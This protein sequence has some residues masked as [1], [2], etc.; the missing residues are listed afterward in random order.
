MAITRKMQCLLRAWVLYRQFMAQ[1]LFKWYSFTRKASGGFRISSGTFAR[2]FLWF[3]QSQ[4]T[5]HLVWMHCAKI[6]EY[7]RGAEAS[8]LIWIVCF[9]TLGGTDKIFAPLKPSELFSGVVLWTWPIISEKFVC[10]WHLG[11]GV[12]S[13]VTP[14]GFLYSD[15]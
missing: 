10:K 6:M 8:Y 5:V 11:Y 15:F 13:T 4:K 9:I 12:N 1:V 14:P 3:L 2:N 7:I